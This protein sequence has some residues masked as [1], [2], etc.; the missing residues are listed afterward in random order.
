MSGIHNQMQIFSLD[1]INVPAEFSIGNGFR[2]I[3]IQ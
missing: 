3:P 1:L 2:Y